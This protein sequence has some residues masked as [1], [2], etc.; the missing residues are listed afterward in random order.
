MKDI[1]LEE[2]GELQIEDG[3]FAIGG[4]T[5]QN[6]TLIL[7]AHQGEFKNT[8]AI[9]VGIGDLLLSDELLEFRHRIRSQ[10]A[11]DGLKIKKLELYEIGNLKIDASYE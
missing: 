7:V 3:D 10:F 6:Q 1:L 2:S 9:G 4:S 5:I 11:M 8:P